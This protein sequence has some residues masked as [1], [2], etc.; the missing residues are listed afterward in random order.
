MVDSGADVSWFNS[1]FATQLGFV[2]DHAALQNASGIGAA[3]YWQ[4]KIRITACGKH[5]NA[6]AGFSPTWS[7]PY[8]LLGQLDFFKEFLVAF[9][10]SHDQLYYHPV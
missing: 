5:F 4:F 10:K 3:Q 1:A 2:L 7:K 9:D 6:E 8:S